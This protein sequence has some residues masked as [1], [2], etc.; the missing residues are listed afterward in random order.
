M[1]KQRAQGCLPSKV[2]EMAAPTESV[3]ENWTSIRAHA[4]IC[5][6]A[7]LPPKVARMATKQSVK[8]KTRDN[9][10][11]VQIIILTVVFFSAKTENGTVKD[12]TILT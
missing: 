6:V 4:T 3:L 12:K 5:S 7:R 8:L 11:T 9:C 10:F 2:F 1:V